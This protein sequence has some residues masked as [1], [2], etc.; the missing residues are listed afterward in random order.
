MSEEGKSRS[1]KDTIIG[2][3]GLGVIII[4]VWV[5]GDITP[6]GKVI[7]WGEAIVAGLLWP[8]SV[9]QILFG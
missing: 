8:I 3:Y 5:H 1:A 2:I 4:A 6:L 9:Y 7:G